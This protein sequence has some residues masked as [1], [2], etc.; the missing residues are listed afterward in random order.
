MNNE[1]ISREAL[2]KDIMSK[3]PTNIP[4]NDIML[5]IHCIDNAPTVEE[6]SVIEFKEPLPLVKAQKIVKTLSKRPQ[7]G[8]IEYKPLDADF[9][10]RAAVENLRTAY[11]SNEPEKVA[12]AFS[13]AEDIIISA[14]CHHGYT[15]C[16]ESEAE[17]ENCSDRSLLS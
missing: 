17:N 13:E 4:S 7:G 5:A 16:K 10:I 3:R 11:W 8:L 9:N 1:L 15:V 6:V 2:K 14:I 12:K